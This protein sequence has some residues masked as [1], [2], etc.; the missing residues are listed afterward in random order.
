LNVLLPILTGQTLTFIPR[1]NASNVILTIT[2][3]STHLST[4]IS[5]ST[6]Y[7]N[8]Y[9]SVEV[10]YDFYEGGSYTYEVLDLSQNLLYRGKIFSTGQTD[11]ENYNINQDLL[12][13]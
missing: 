4:G 1:E 3:E 11:L 8:G 12:Q 9:M 2:D 10:V 7:L 5:G 13:A 6:V